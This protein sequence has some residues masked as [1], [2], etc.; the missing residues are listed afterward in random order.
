MKREIV[1][2]E[3]VIKAGAQGMA[4]LPVAKDTII[5]P[6]AKDVAKKH[7]ITFQ[8]ATDKECDM[9]EILDPVTGAEKFAPAACPNEEKS[10]SPLPSLPLLRKTA[11]CGQLSGMPPAGAHLKPVPCSANEEVVQAVIRQ[12][13]DDFRNR[14]GVLEMVR[15]VVEETLSTISPK[16]ITATPGA[17]AVS[18]GR[19]FSDGGASICSHGCS[20][21]GPVVAVDGTSICFD[22]FPGAPQGMVN[23]ADVITSRNNSPMGGGFLE[24]NNYSFTWFLTYAEV[25][26]VLEGELHIT[27]QGKTVVGKS[28][29]MLFIPKDTEV[30][31]SSPGHVRFAYVTWPADWSGTLPENKGAM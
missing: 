17:A 10:L 7:G 30:I 19:A 13:P 26:I 29:D 4:N 11:A 12:L 18:P 23:I 8:K 5:T 22:H 28:G 31:F 6:S 9:K 15:K 1:T 3:V 27:C 20:K 16:G 14:E 25:D 24:W 21:A 2:A